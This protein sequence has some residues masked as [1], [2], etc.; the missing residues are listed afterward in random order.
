MVLPKKFLQVVGTY[1]GRLLLCESRWVVILLGDGGDTWPLFCIIK[2]VWTF[3]TKRWWGAK[4]LNSHFLP[5]SLAR[6]EWATRWNFHYLFLSRDQIW[7]KIHSHRASALLLGLMLGM[8]VGSIF[9]HDGKR[10]SLNKTVEINY[11]SFH[12][13][14]VET[15]CE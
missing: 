8:G 1:E 7:I 3:W 11:I 2:L 10:H 13:V 15:Q 14:N 6:T 5:G 4:N 12:S 9:K